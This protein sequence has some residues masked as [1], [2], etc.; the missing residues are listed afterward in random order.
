MVCARTHECPEKSEDSLVCSISSFPFHVG[1]RMELKSSGTTANA[2]PR[3]PCISIKRGFKDT[4]WVL[5]SV[6]AFNRCVSITVTEA[7]SPLASFAQET[8]WVAPESLEKYTENKWQTSAERNPCLVLKWL[9]IFLFSVLLNTKVCLHSSG[10]LKVAKMLS[11]RGKK[12]TK[13][14]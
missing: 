1:S 3:Y 8:V 7:N 10:W 9:V 6:S 2:F 12:W 13:S 5:T 11:K 4:S 14:H